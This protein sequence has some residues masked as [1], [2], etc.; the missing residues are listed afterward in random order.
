MD[1]NAGPFHRGVQTRMTGRALFDTRTNRFTLFE[2]VAT[3]TRW[4]GTR[5]NARHDD[6]HAARNAAWDRIPRYIKE[7]LDAYPYRLG[8]PQEVLDTYHHHYD[9]CVAGAL[10]AQS[11]A[12]SDRINGIKAQIFQTPATTGSAA[13]WTTR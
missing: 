13:D 1:R 8:A 5:Y 10:D 3:G 7:A 2:L 6:L 4:G 12:V 9:A 11:D